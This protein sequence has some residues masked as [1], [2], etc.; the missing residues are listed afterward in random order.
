MQDL[1]ECSRG[2]MQAIQSRSMV[3][4]PNNAEYLE[5][6][7][8]LAG[9]KA[10]QKEVVALPEVAVP[11]VEQ[12]LMRELERIHYGSSSEEDEQLQQ[13]V[14]FRKEDEAQVQGGGGD[15]SSELNEL[16]NTKRAPRKWLRKR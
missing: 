11:L 7:R 6:Q 13:P 4:L 15:I 9:E 12:R 5:S 2:N 8:R 14:S 3:L 1:K 10:R 16:L